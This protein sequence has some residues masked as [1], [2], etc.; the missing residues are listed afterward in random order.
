MHSLLSWAV[1]TKLLWTQQV[2]IILWFL[3]RLIKCEKWD[4]CRM[5]VPSIKYQQ[6]H[7]TSNVQFREH[8]AM[9][10]AWNSHARWNM[11]WENSLIWRPLI[12]PILIQSHVP[13][14]IL[15]FFLLI[16]FFYSYFRCQCILGI[17][18]QFLLVRRNM[19]PFGG[20][21]FYKVWDTHKANKGE[22]AF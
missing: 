8:R 21:K 4:L 22:C 16:I 7:C 3:R 1:P 11:S 15:R 12:L 20:M 18:H 6:I 13:F 14:G 17:S 10:V 9:S 5:E 19:T 2:I